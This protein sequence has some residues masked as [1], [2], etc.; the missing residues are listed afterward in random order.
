MKPQRKPWR[1]MLC[2]CGWHSEAYRAK[3]SRVKEQMRVHRARCV[4]ARK[5]DFAE[6]TLE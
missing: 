6:E 4:K 5:H 3:G 1:R 2:R